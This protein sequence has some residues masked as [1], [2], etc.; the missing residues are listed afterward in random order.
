MKI[1]TLIIIILISSVLCGS[2][3]GA[4]EEKQRLKDKKILM[5]IGSSNYRDEE[6]LE[7]KKIFEDEGAKVVIASTTLEPI[8]GM[9]GKIVK[10][11][12]LIDD[13]KVD[14]Y[15]AIIF[16]GG[17]GAKEYWDNEKAHQIA[18]DAIEKEKKLGAICIAP[19]IL[20]K[21][22]VLKDKKATVWKSERKQLTDKG[23]EYTG[24]YLE[25]D[26]NIITADGPQSARY[27]GLAILNA[28]LNKE[29]K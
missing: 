1:R 17:A 20:A 26:G 11:D 8:K 14:D 13:V 4:N 21:A 24:K 7:P 9:L 12:I 19:V 5:I 25:V 23:A 2:I 15:E 29:E 3:F 16:V 28:L 22:G 6:L 27:F 18:K 10:A